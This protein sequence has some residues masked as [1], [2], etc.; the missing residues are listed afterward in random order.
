LSHNDL[1]GPLRQLQ[2]TEFND[3]DFRK[4][5]RTIN[6]A[7][8]DNKLKDVV[9][10]QVFEMWWPRLEQKFRDILDAEEMPEEKQPLR[11]DREILEEILELSRLNHRSIARTPMVPSGLVRELSESLITAVNAIQGETNPQDAPTALATMR[12]PIE[13]LFTRSRLVSEPMSSEIL[14][15]LE[16][17][18]FEYQ[19]LDEDD[20]EIPDRLSLVSA[21]DRARLEAIVANRNRAQKHV[22]RARIILARPSRGRGEARRVRRLPVWRWQR[23]FAEGRVEGL[24]RI[25]TR[26]PD[27]AAWPP[28]RCAASWR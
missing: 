12:K 4:L 22:A 13:F 15:G 14:S 23:R 3:E 18:S 16:A 21:E 2:G 28:V 19:R 7:A 27:K 5:L 24:L 25:A 1:P 8:G 9:L 20:D 10:D 11:K 26:K 17:L 6:S